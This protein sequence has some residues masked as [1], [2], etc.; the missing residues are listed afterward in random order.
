MIP[1]KCGRYSSKTGKTYV[2]IYSKEEQRKIVEAELE[3]KS[4]QSAIREIIETLTDDDWQ[5]VTD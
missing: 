1:T 3:G 5:E 4:T 2:H